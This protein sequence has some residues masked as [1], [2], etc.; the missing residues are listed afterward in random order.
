MKTFEKY[1]KGINDLGHK[2]R[3]EEIFTWIKEKYP[4]LT[5]KDLRLCAF[6]R[7][8]LTSKEIAPLMGISVRGVENHR[9]RSEYS[10][11]PESQSRW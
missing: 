11:I 3:L 7:M 10:E 9:Y 2:Q 8:N 6:L 4:E 5:S 1:L